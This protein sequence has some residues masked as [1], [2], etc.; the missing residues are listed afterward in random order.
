[1]AVFTSLRFFVQFSER[2][3]NPMNTVKWTLLRRGELESIALRHLAGHKG[4]HADVCRL[5]SSLTSTEDAISA[6]TNPEVEPEPSF[7]VSVVLA[8]SMR[9]FISYFLV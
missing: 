4:F 2:F 6:D 9:L 5:Q 1:M 3:Y 7:G 8:N